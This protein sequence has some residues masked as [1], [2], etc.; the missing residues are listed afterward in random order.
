MIPIIKFGYEQYLNAYI[1][2]LQYPN[3]QEEIEYKAGKVK[4]IIDN[5]SF[6]HS[7]DTDHGSSRAPIILLNTEKVIGIHIGGDK[8][9]PIN[10]GT[11]IVEIFNEIIVNNNY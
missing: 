2:S 4:K 10:Y 1:F 9:D 3:N 5:I 11:F 8:K 7:I 6:E